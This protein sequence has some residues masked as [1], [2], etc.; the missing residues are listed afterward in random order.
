[1]LALKYQGIKLTKEV[2]DL[3]LKIYKTWLKEIEDNTHTYTQRR[4]YIPC[5]YIG[6]FSIVKIITLRKEIFRF[7]TISVKIL[8]SFSSKN[9][10]K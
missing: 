3:Y 9:Y 7:I 1:M 2:K 8:I 10:K 4:K 6:K 5:S